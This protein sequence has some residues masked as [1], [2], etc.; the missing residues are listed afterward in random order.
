MFAYVELGSDGLL[1]EASW[2]LDTGLLP[3]TNSATRAIGYRQVILVIFWSI[4]LLCIYL[5][6]FSSMYLLCNDFLWLV[7]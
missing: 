5:F 2:L 3:N 4:C 7:L 6:Y 1:S